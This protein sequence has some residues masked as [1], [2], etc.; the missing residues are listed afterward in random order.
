[1]GKHSWVAAICF[2]ALAACGG[3]GS[4]GGSSNVGNGPGVVLTQLVDPAKG[5]SIVVDAPNNAL[6]GTVV[7]IPANALG[8]SGTDT[9]SIGYSDTLP[10]SLDPAAVAAGARV[11]SKV[12]QLTHTSLAEFAASITVTVPYDT[13]TVGPNDVPIVLYWD[14]SLKQYDAVK[15]ISFARAAGTVTFRTHH[16]S[17]FIVGYINGLFAAMSGTV[18]IPGSIDSIDTKFR[19]E[20]NGFA[21]ENFSSLNGVADGGACYGLTAF[22]RW[23]FVKNNPA[24]FS[25]VFGSTN[26]LAGNPLEMDLARELIYATYATT[27]NENENSLADTNA[28]MILLSERDALTA[29]KLVSY[30]VFTQLPQMLDLYEKKDFSNFPVSIGAAHSVLVYSW[31]FKQGFM[32]YDPNFPSVHQ[33]IKFNW[34]NFSPYTSGK[35]YELFET[36]APSSFYS[37]GDLSKLYA[38]A[39]GGSEHQFSGEVSILPDNSNQALPAGTHSIDPTSGTTIYGTVTRLN[40]AVQLYAY[41]YLDDILI[42]SGQPVAADGS[43]NKQIAPLASGKSSQELLIIVAAPSRE[44]TSAANQSGISD[45]YAGSARATVVVAGSNAMITITSAACFNLPLNS[46]FPQMRSYRVDLSGKATGPVDA[47]IAGFS[48]P[49]NGISHTSCT[50]WSSFNTI[51]GPLCKR[52]AS[53]SASTAWSSSDIIETDA[54]NPIEGG[55][56]YMYLL[57]PNGD[58]DTIAGT[59]ELRI[60]GCQ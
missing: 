25:N 23:T 22:A 34:P 10:G 41:F 11:V 21:V 2:A 5:A 37:D 36:D 24:L 26:L 9:I 42:G 50:N 40:P 19:P 27:L 13:A 38:A 46:N 44:G 15:V 1:M 8:A 20:T 32:I 39:P 55:N 60:T 59:D 14:E 35:T 29:Q 51:H 45:S 17:N 56:G 31:K 43:F 3:G 33:N 49:S 7:N 6:N 47:L 57:L 18:Q 53:D 12:I 16:F 28:P 58:F 4:S 30:M 48:N 54:A 52:T